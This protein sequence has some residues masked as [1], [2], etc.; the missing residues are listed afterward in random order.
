MS[1]KAFLKKCLMDFFII[2]TC[3][4]AAMAILGASIAPTARFGYEAYFSPLIFGLVSLIP[5]FVNYSRKELSLKQALIRK[6]L[7]FIALEVTLITFSYLT[8]LITGINEVFS[9]AVT[10]FIVYLAVNLISWW[11]DRKEAGEI[12]K[13]IKALQDKKEQ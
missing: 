12:N 9:F 6:V 7:H 5:S 4:T 13:M 11:L 2:A 3:V 10:V 8:G 1:F